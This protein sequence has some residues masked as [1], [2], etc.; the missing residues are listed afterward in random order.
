MWV[1][2]IGTLQRAAETGVPAFPPVKIS[3]AAAAA[4]DT[5]H[6][7]MVLAIIQH[8]WLFGLAISFVNDAPFGL[9]KAQLRLG[10]H[11]V[12]PCAAMGETRMHR[13]DAVLDALQPVAVLKALNGDVNVALADEK[14]ITRHQRHRL[15]A[16]IGEDKPPS[17]STGYEANEY[18]VS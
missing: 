15:R 1:S 7:Q 5:R 14:I 17:S 6:Q 10:A 4:A 2:S 12:R 8:A 3:P 18:L 16:E 9:V 13:V 11:D